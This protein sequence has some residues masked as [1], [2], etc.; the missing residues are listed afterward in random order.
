MPFFAFTPDRPPLKPTGRAIAAGLSDLKMTLAALK[1]RP[2]LIRFLF[3]R[4]LFMDGVNGIL[5]L[6][7][8]FA[9]GMFGW[10]TMEIGIFGIILN[11]AAIFG[12]FLASRFGR[13]ANASTVVLI[14]LLVLVLATLGVVSTTKNATIFGLLSFG[15]SSAEGLFAA[16]AEKA[17]LAY[18]VLIG[19]AFGPVQ[20]GSR[21][22][23][24]TR[25]SPEEA[26]RFFGLFRSPAG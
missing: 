19:L 16:G 4:M 9:A 26:G 6:G 12:C 18:G 21:A 20:A 23:L 3:A 1:G 13:R 22:F 8:A 11:V 10:A 25:V 7:G 15:P 17:F 5:I 2:V 14:A 24:A